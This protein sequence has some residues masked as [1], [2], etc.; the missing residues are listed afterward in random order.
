LGRIDRLDLLAG[1]FERLVVPRGVAAE[2]GRLPDWV[3]V[4]QVKSPG[5]LASYPPRIHAGEA[6]VIQLGVE[7]PRAILVLDDWYARDFARHRGLNFLGTVGLLLRAKRDGRLE[8]LLPVLDELA[9]A[10]FRVSR[11]V[12]DEALRLAGELH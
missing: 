4:E 11:L 6:E 2:V 9:K 5:A 1:H 7:N 10:D 3:V 12:R 8:A